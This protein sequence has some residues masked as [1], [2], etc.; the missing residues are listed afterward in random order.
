LSRNDSYPFTIRRSKIAGRGAFATRRIRKGQEVIEYVGE[1]ITEKE[2]DRRYPDDDRV[3][4]HHTFLFA[5]ENGMVIDATYGGNISRYINHSCD[6][7]CESIEEDGHI[8]IQAMRNIQPGTELTYD[9]LYPRTSRDTKKDEALYPCYCGSPK[10]RGTIMEPRKRR[11]KK[12]GKGKQRRAVTGRR[13]GTGR[14]AGR[15]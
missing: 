4:Q 9:Y 10:C 12:R 5:L 6:P 3:K 14:K 1:L 7:N 8:Y 11:R 13:T 2:S 15:R